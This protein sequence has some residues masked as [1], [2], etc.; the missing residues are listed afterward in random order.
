VINR[1][2]GFNFIILKINMKKRVFY[3]RTIDIHITR[4]LLALNS[5]YILWYQTI[6][7]KWISS[8]NPNN[9]VGL[10]VLAMDSL[11]KSLLKYK[12]IGRSLMTLVD[13][14]Y[15]NLNNHLLK[16]PL[17]STGFV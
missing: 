8:F 16:N 4:K 6:Y 5:H 14:Y 15:V 7:Q 3:F 10:F 11:V 13:V 17:F 9:L 12:P 1:K 2:V